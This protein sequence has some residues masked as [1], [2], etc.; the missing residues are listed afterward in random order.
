MPLSHLFFTVAVNFLACRCDKRRLCY[1]KNSS[2]GYKKDDMTN[3]ALHPSFLALQGGINFRDLGGQR[4]ADGRQIR[5]HKLLRAGALHRITT[6][7]LHQLGTL[8]LNVI[9][10]YRDPVEVAR[11]PDNLSDGMRYLNVPANPHSSG[12]NAKVTEFN[13]ATLDVI[14]GEQF[15][16]ELYRQ[17]PFNNPA[18]RQLAGCLTQPLD[19]ALLQHCAVG[20]DRTGVGCALAL[21]AL[22]ADRNTV[23]EEYLL[24][25]GMLSQVENEMLGWL[26]DGLSERGRQ[27]LTALLDVRESYLSAAL[28]EIHLRY[29]STDNWLSHEY[30]LTPDVR[31]AIQSR[32]LSD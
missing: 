15:M 6:E 3:T 18:Y 4:G 1:D 28:N 21:F 2:G 10:D 8:P 14:D 25:H 13:A 24:T 12:V 29:G 23:M 16:L 31:R 20:K 9:L 5:H 26:G 27:N 11:S 17:L 32:L 30:Q 19:G 7:D 22:G